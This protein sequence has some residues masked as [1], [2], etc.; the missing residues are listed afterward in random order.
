MATAI[1]MATLFHCISWA[2]FPHSY[3]PFNK[4]KKGILED[5]SSISWGSE[6]PWL[7]RNR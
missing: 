2:N 4:A 3:F 6:P 1:A 7:R 5:I